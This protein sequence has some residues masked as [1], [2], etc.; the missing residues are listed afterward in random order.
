M[1]TTLAR[2]ALFLV[3]FCYGTILSRAEAPLSPVILV[4]RPSAINEFT[5]DPAQVKQM[6]NSAL[7]TLTSS[8]DIGTA[9]RRLGITP[10]DIVGIKINTVGGPAFCT[11]HSLVRAICSGLEAAGVPASQ[12]IIWDKLPDRMTKAG[13]APQVAAPGQP[14]I[15]SVSPDHYDPQVTYH[16]GVIGSLIYGDYQFVDS[17]DYMGDPGT[18]PVLTYSY[19]TSIVTQTCTKIINV[20]VLTDDAFIGMKGCLGSLALG[21]VDNNR[22][23]QGPPTYGDPDLC[24]ILNRPFFRDKVVVNILDALVA[25]YAG[26]PK[27]H[28]EFTAEPGAIYVSRDPV[29]IDSLVLPRLEKWRLAANVPPIGSTASYI[30]DAAS[31]GLGTTNKSLI[32]LIRLP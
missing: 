18:D 8:Q 22:R 14:A 21:S 7:L 15:M 10:K 11:H 4:E 31:Y 29:A 25:Q 3:C 12:I 28:P 26:G 17:L 27:F 20:P 5:A 19:Y 24:S 9:W 2:L 32:Q 1:S 23:F 6:V 30:Q 13:Y 16:S